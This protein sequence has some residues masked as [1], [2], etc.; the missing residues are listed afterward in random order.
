MKTN[1]SYFEKIADLEKD[2][3]L[4]FAGDQLFFIV[5]KALETLTSSLYLT[6]NYYEISAPEAQKNLHEAQKIVEWLISNNARRDCVLVG[7]GGGATLDLTGFVA[8][9]YQRGVNH[10]FIPTSLLAMVDASIGGKTAV[11]LVYKNSIGTFW[12][13]HTTLICPEFLANLDIS[14]ISSGIGEIIKVALLKDMSILHDLKDNR[15]IS[16][17]LIKKVVNVKLLYVE[18][19]YRDNTIRKHLNFGHTFGHLIEKD[20]N[21]QV[22]HGVA[23]ANGIYMILKLQEEL[24]FAFNHDLLAKVYEIL[25]KYELYNQDIQNN[26]EQYKLELFAF[27]KKTLAHSRSLVFLSDWEKPY[28]Y[29][30]RRKEFEYRCPDLTVPNNKSLIQRDMMLLAYS[31]DF[32]TLANYGKYCTSEDTVLL[33]KALLQHKA[34][35]KVFHLTQSATSLKCLLIYLLVKNGLSNLSTTYVINGH[36]SLFLRPLDSFWEI[37]KKN[38]VTFSTTATSITVSG[39]LKN[40]DYNFISLKSSQFVSAI[41]LAAPF[42]KK[43]T[44][45]SFPTSI[46]SL[47]FIKLTIKLLKEDNIRIDEFNT[48]DKMN[49]CINGSTSKFEFKPHLELDLGMAAN[50]FVLAMFL[51]NSSVTV[52]NYKEFSQSLQVDKDVIEI[53]KNCGAKI[54]ITEQAISVESSDDLQAINVD[55]TN[56]L[57]LAPILFVYASQ[58]KRPSIFTGF[59][60]LKYKE[61]DRLNCVLDELRKINTK[62]ELSEQELKISKSD[63]DFRNDVT[64]DDYSDH[65]LYFAFNILCKLIGYGKVTNSKSHYKTWSEFPEELEK[66]LYEKNSKY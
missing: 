51:K 16:L 12:L 29:D 18:K 53:F 45:L 59:Q 14:Q 50:M 25:C 13:P 39:G 61:S 3:K 7:I 65:R 27:D 30:I 9:I 34:G 56:T 19:D 22:A 63:L 49:V 36:K 64:F 52:K 54:S 66:G 60:N 47:S 28:I 33:H 46:A 11:N 37:F 8:S 1:I 42:L 31:G 41:L 20:A 38:N 62:I 2:F 10:I 43:R 24:G 48:N 58:I 26:Y 6:H 44:L 32:S 57:D 55:L 21:F 23:V 15:T 4:N 5:D 35:A 17:D 40:L